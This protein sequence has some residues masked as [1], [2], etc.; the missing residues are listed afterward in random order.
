MGNFDTG[1]LGLLNLLRGWK[2]EQIFRSDADI[3][4]RL[5]L[6]PNAFTQESHLFATFIDCRECYLQPIR[7]DRTLITQLSQISALGLTIHSTETAGTDR[8]KIYCSFDNTLGNAQLSLQC[9]DFNLY[10]ENF[11]RLKPADLMQLEGKM[12]SPED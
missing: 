7:N 2:I 6:P 1:K 5:C 10:N 11:D 4:L 3:S 8:L 9:S 12:D